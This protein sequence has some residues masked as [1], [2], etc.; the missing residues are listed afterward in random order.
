MKLVKRRN[1]QLRTRKLDNYDQL[2]HSLLKHLS[3]NVL[4]I[5]RLFEG[6]QSFKSSDLSRQ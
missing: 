5:I 3:N 6:K 2:S 4:C 1:V